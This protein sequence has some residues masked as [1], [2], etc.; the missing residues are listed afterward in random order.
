MHQKKA[1]NQC[2]RSDDTI[3]VISVNKRFQYNL[4]KRFET[5]VID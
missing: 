5:N 2:V 1:Y 4:T 3:I